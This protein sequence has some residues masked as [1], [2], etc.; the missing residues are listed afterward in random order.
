[1]NKILNKNKKSLKKKLGASKN[2]R[3]LIHAINDFEKSTDLLVSDRISSKEVSFDCKKGC[4]I[5]CNLRVEVLPPE[6]FNIARYIRSLP[7]SKQ[8]YYLLKLNEHSEYAADKKFVDYNKPCPFLTGEGSCGIYSVRPHKCRAYLSKSV[9]VCKS[10]RDA[11]E[12]LKLGMLT[13]QLANDS[14][15]IYKSKKLVMHPTELGQGVLTTLENKE[16]EEVC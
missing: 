16:I 9:S 5:C 2:S 6:V 13:K 11:E 10:G 12:D 4:D 8:K 3:L 1:M 14:V 7:D 15:Q